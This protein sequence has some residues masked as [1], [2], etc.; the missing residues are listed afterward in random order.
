MPI[1]PD[2]Q[3][4]REVH[5]VAGTDADGPC[6][7]LNLNRYRERAAYDGPVPG[8]LDPDVSGLEAY[9]RYGIVAQQVLE[10][11]G[12]RILWH[13]PCTRTVIGD[14]TDVFDDAI[15]VWYP[16]LRAFAE[17]IS[18]EDLRAAAVHRAAGL[19]RAAVISLAWGADPVPSPHG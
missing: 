11:V 8:G 5:A 10:R 19:D 16:S 15:A 6:V 13:T 2:E 4:E 14:D 3:Q 1:E 17:L 18:A 9:V 7:M 12:A